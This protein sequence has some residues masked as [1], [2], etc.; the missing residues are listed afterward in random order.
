MVVSMRHTSSQ[1]R[2]RRSHR[3]LKKVT[4]NK[5]QK[6]GQAVRPHTV[7]AFCGSYKGREVIKIKTKKK[8]EKKA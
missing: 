7:C 5:C 8:K 3:S 2:R 4:L 1:A 6:C